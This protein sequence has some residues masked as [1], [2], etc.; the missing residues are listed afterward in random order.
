MCGRIAFSHHGRSQLQTT[1]RTIVDRHVGFAMIHVGAM[2]FHE[3]TS[4][5]REISLQFSADLKH[6]EYLKSRRGNHHWF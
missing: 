3:V 6:E 4:V 2:L 1:I 5:E